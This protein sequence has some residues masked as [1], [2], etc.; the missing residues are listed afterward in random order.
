MFG[1]ARGTYHVLTR[2]R[3]A[4][5]HMTSMNHEHGQP[6]PTRDDVDA[7]DCAGLR[8]RRSEQAS[9]SGRHRK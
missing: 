5:Q 3:C 4:A 2:C 8:R 1:D 7:A 6:K 9:S